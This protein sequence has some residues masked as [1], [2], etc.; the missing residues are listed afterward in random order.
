MIE[1]AL[2]VLGIMVGAAIAVAIRALI[3]LTSTQHAPADVEG[4]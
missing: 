1:L 3:E 2:F 4:L